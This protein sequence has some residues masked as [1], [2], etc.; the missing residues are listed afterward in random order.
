MRAKGAS[1]NQFKNEKSD[2]FFGAWQNN[3]ARDERCKSPGVNQN[4]N[5]ETSQLFWDKSYLNHVKLVPT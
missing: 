1:K 5:K 4:D 3:T 2:S